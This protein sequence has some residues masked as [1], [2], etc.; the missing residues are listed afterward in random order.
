VYEWQRLATAMMFDVLGF[1]LLGTWILV[2]S[3]AG[4]RSGVLPRGIGWFGVLTAV[5][6]LCFVAGYVSKVPWLGETGLGAAA[7]VAL[8]AWLIWLG[9]VLW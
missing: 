8:P 2:S 9:A 3:V 4:L 6:C 5:L 7:F 1:F